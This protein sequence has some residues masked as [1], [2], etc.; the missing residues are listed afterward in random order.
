MPDAI[1]FKLTL[2][3]LCETLQQAGYRVEQVTDPVANVRR[4]RS[5]TGGL[6]FDV[7]P[8]N[9]LAGDDLAFADVSFVTVL[10][11]PGELPLEL[12]NAWNVNR[13][14][15]RLQLSRM[16]Q[17]FLVFCMDLSVGGGVTADHLRLQIETWDRLAQELI[18]YLRDELRKLGET[19]GASP[20]VASNGSQPPAPERDLRA[21]QEPAAAVR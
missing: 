13:R 10:Q 5:S 7:Y 9:R 17:S 2:D 21:G 11:A 6:A 20:Q 15:A 14:F 19:G 8:G 16:N 4:L 3:S 12:V 18:A 1:I